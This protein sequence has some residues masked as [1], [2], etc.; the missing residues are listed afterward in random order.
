MFYILV[1]GKIEIAKSNS[2]WEAIFTEEQARRLYPV[3]WLAY[4][5]ESGA[6]IGRQP[7]DLNQG[8]SMPIHSIENQLLRSCAYTFIECNKILEKKNHDYS[9]IGANPY[10]NFEAVER[11]GLCSAE[12]GIL[13]RIE[14]KLQRITNLMKIKKMVTDETVEDTINDAINYLAILKA[15]LQWNGKVEGNLQGNQNEE[16]ARCQ[17][18]S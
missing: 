14:D 7:Q 16:N 13:I 11:R 4:L 8:E 3:Q 6:T 12:I 2:N 17:P 5:N 18:P 10:L 1:D 9:G 15:R